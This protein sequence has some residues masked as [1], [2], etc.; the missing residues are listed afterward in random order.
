[1]VMEMTLVFQVPD[2]FFFFSLIHH[3]LTGRI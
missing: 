3:V 2:V 1:M